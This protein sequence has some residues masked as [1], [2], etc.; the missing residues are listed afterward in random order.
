MHQMQHGGGGSGLFVKRCPLVASTHYALALVLERKTLWSKQ[1]KIDEF[2]GY[3]H[4][5]KERLSQVTK[6]IFTHLHINSY[7]WQL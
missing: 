1:S 6:V 5:A 7:L 3:A 2:A 4:T